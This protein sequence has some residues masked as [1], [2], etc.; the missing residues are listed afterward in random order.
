MLSDKGR[1]MGWNCEKVY[2]VPFKELLVVQ[3]LKHFYA[4]LGK[5]MNKKKL[6]EFRNK[7]QVKNAHITKYHIHKL[8]QNTDH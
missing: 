1:T 5:T 2:S 3:L 8:C 7:F 6:D 4:V